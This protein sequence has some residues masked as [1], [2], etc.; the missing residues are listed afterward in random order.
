[1][2]GGDNY[3]ESGFEESVIGIGRLPA[4]QGK[5]KGNYERSVPGGKTGGEY[6]AEC[7]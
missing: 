2:R 4:E 6:S 1:M 5:I 7:I 3:Y